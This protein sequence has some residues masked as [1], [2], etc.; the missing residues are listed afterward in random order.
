[1]SK[2]YDSSIIGKK[3]SVVDE[4]LLLNPHQTPLLNMLGFAEPVA[5]T[6]HQWF[7]DEMYG[8]ESTVVGAKLVGDT[9]VVVADVEPFRPGHVVKIGEELLLVT[10]INAGT[11]TLTVTRGYADTTPAA[12]ADGAVIE[13]QF[14]E[15][16]E[17]ADAR[18]ARY[19]ARKPASNITQIFDDSVEISGTA[20]AVTQY[21]ISDLY[22]YEKQKKQLELALQL[23]KALIN[24]VLYQN[25]EIRQ[26]KGVRQFIQTNVV[27]VNGDLALDAI[28]NLAQDIYE[29]GG[30]KTAGDY[31][32]LVGAKQKRKLSKLDTNKVSITRGENSR[33]EV[34]DRLVNDFGEF[35]IELN[36]NLAPDELLFVDANRMA[37]RP[38]VGREF[39]HKFMGE[40]GDYTVGMLVGEYTLEF[41][42][43]KAHG[44]LKGLN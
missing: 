1:M 43:E 2:I 4:I 25:G 3:Q 16:T 34:V 36:N 35:D 26:M 41:K 20:Q 22:E 15:G 13:V 9:E 39:F 31:K 11:K 23:E 19:K 8:D 18:S 5:Q 6:T 28:D 21:G 44:R 37:I 27:N 38:L 14:V 7:E 40:K 24:G 30:F 32:V 42:Q 33:G 17:G 10:A 12:I 29:A